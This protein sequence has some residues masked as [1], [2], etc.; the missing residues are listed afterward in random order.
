M[1]GV[2]V[3]QVLPAVDLVMQQWAAGQ[4]PD[5]PAEYD[6]ANTSQRVTNFIRSTV[7]SHAAWSGLHPNPRGS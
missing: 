2:G 1:C 7:D 3:E 5:V 6:V 4:R